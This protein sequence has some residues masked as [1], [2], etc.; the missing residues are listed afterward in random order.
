MSDTA[1]PAVPVQSGL[2]ATIGVLVLFALYASLR[3][4][5][6]SDRDNSATAA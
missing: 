4:D 3:Q 2:P 5:R 6:R 1:V